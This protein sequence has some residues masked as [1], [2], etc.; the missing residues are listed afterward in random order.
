MCVKSKRE[1]LQGVDFDWE[2]PRSEKDQQAYATLLIEASKSFNKADLLISVALHPRQFMPQRVYDE[3]DRY[4]KDT[5]LDIEK[6]CQ[7]IYDSRVCLTFFDSL[8]LMLG[9]ISW[10]MIW[11]MIMWPNTIP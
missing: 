11:I 5:P 6:G 7:R 2:I 3:M 4:I 8:F 1:G 9:S 10:H